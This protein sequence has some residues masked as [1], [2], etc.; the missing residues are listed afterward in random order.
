M[1]LQQL[2]TL[3]HL[4]GDLET[5]GINRADMDTAMVAAIWTM[6][7]MLQEH[8]V[9]VTPEV[10]ALCNRYLQLRFLELNG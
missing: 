7:H 9:D 5:E 8:H 2:I 1:T 10:F 4:V 3:R 6:T